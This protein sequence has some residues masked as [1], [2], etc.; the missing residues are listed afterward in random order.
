MHRTSADVAKA[1]GMTL[2]LLTKPELWIFISTFPSVVPSTY[3]DANEKVQ[4]L[5]LK[6]FKR[7]KVS[8]TW[9]EKG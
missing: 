9:K 4:Q 6:T 7:V 2:F 5:H 1:A 8:I 3:F